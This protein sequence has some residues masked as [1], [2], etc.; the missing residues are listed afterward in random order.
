MKLLIGDPKSGKVLTAAKGAS[1]DEVK[2]TVEPWRNASEQK[3]ELQKID[4]KQLTM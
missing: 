1:D 2:I 3:W 4:P